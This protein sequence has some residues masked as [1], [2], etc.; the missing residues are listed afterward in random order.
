MNRAVLFAVIAVLAAC[1]GPPGQDGRPGITGPMGDKGDPGPGAAAGITGVFPREIAV[2][3]KGQVAISGSGTSWNDAAAVSFGGDIS[4]TKVR[5]A[6]PNALIVDLEVSKTATPGLREISVVQGG[7]SPLQY[8]NVFQITPLISMAVSGKPARGSLVSVTVTH[9]DPLFEFDTSWSGTT[10][11]GISATTSPSGIVVVRDVKPHQVT[12]LASL[13]TDA[14]LGA[15]DLRLISSWK[16][17]SE[18]T[19]S[20]PAAFEV[21]DLSEQTLGLATSGTLAQAFDSVLYK[22]TPLTTSVE[23]LASV[24]TTNGKGSPML[25]LVPTNGRFTTSLAFINS[26][27]FTPYSIADYRFVVV[28][29]SGTPGVDYTM[30]VI[31]PNKVA[32][33]EPNE[34]IAMPQVA[35]VPS[36]IT[37]ATL[38]SATDVD[39]Y[40]VTVTQAEEGRSLRIRTRPGDYST[41]LR[42]ELQLADGTAVMSPVDLSYHED[43]RSP[44]LTAA[45]D[46]YV[47]LSWGRYTTGTWSMYS[48]RYDLL[49]NWE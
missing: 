24:T 31:T 25:V 36:I 2:G 12:L 42:V 10:F 5:A 9:H 37:P 19:I 39:V 4:V 11:T 16:R 43:V 49:L 22:F 17:P 14:P 32:E 21:A 28:D 3:L 6:S 45:G 27:S 33:A 46:Y 48:S 1:E 15:R 18:V 13:D 7:G 29:P 35:T 30:S 8:R 40:K 41:D 26:Y 34:G 47:K 38:S 44:P 20:F 23:L